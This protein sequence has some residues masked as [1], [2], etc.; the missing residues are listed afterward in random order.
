[1]E[2]NGLFYTTHQP[3][4]EMLAVVLAKS[5]TEQSDDCTTNVNDIKFEWCMID[6]PVENGPSFNLL[7]YLPG[8]LLV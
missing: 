6:M 2:P 8:N 3:A 7:T 1:M 5:W 4:E